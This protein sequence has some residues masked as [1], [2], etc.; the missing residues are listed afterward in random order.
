MNKIDLQGNN[1]LEGSWVKC[2]S[3]V[4]RKF[5]LKEVEYKTTL[6]RDLNKPTN[7]VI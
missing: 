3:F 4:P 5:Y 2:G 6:A 1:G 7:V